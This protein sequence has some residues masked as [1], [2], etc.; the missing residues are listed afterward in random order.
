MSASVVISLATAEAS[1]ITRQ[2]RRHCVYTEESA[3]RP[4]AGPAFYI[5]ST[6]A[7]YV[8]LS[9]GALHLL[10]RD[11]VTRIM[12]VDLPASGPCAALPG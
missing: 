9:E 10:P 1:G 3:T 4:A 11:Q 6:Q 5:G 12:R 8:F 7:V 2:T